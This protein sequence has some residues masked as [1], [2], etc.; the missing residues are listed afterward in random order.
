MGETEELLEKI[1][2]DRKLGEEQKARIALHAIDVRLDRL[3]AKRKAIEEL[4][5]E[6]GL[7]ISDICSTLANDIQRQPT[8]NPFFYVTAE[9]FGKA[10]RYFNSKA[11]IEKDKLK[12]HRLAFDMIERDVRK[13]FFG[14]NDD[15][16]DFSGYSCKLKNFYVF[17]NGIGYDLEYEV[18][19][20]G[21][22]KTAMIGIRI[23][24]FA[25]VDAESMS[26]VLNG[27]AATHREADSCVWSTIAN[28][29]DIREVK[30][31]LVKWLV[32]NLLED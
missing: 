16:D 15:Y 5:Y 30:A 31:G 29:L 7:I 11:D 21:T 8:L 24:L 18:K 22:G 14:K 2:K 23:P 10:W 25:A 4:Q 13:Q 20:D 32:D 3:K 6:E 26:Y 19:A 27:F 12:E 17:W 1:A 9:I 28:S